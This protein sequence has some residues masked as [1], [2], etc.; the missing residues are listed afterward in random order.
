MMRLFRQ[1]A[2]CGAATFV[3]VMSFGACCCAAA[4][5][6]AALLAS[7]RSEIVIRTGAPPPQ[8]ELRYSCERVDQ[9]MTCAARSFDPPAPG[10]VETEYR[11]AGDL[12][13]NPIDFEGYVKLIARAPT[14]ALEVIE[15]TGRSVIIFNP[16]G[17]LRFR[18][19]VSQARYSAVQGC[20][21]VHVGDTYQVPAHEF[22]GNWRVLESLAPGQRGPQPGEQVVTIVSSDPA[23]NTYTL[24]VAP[25]QAAPQLNLDPNQFVPAFGQAAAAAARSMEDHVF[26][27]VGYVGPDGQPVMAV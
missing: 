26:V 8:H 4:E 24:Q 3:A 25:L 19:G 20:P 21:T 1:G 14:C 23:Q 7:N 17:T 6:P 12:T 2:T 22:P 16:D 11:L 10:S 27:H 9:K 13:G 15:F 5:I 18:D